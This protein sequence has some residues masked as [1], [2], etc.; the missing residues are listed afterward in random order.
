MP[1][2]FGDTEANSVDA[3]CRK[4]RS[5]TDPLGFHE[6]FFEEGGAPRAPNGLIRFRP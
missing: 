4:S 5:D 6:Q 2:K 3:P 1:G